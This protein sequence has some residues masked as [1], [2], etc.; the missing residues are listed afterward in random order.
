MY[1][2]FE[3]R[4]ELKS[5]TKWILTGTDRYSMPVECAH[6]GPWFS[7]TDPNEIIKIVKL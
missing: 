2:V 1:S 4:T 6:A 3:R 7:T 5:R